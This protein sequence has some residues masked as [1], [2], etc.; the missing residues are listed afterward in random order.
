MASSTVVFGIWSL[1]RLC[2]GLGTCWPGTPAR[3]SDC[4]GAAEASS[5]GGSVGE[6]G[7]GVTA[8]WGGGLKTRLAGAGGRRCSDA[9]RGLRS[10]TFTS[11]LTLLLLGAFCV[12]SV[13]R[14]SVTR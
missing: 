9:F 5:L 7:R 3:G 8:V 6:P 10:S 13:G 1:D 4:G 11:L 2:C 14:I 12:R